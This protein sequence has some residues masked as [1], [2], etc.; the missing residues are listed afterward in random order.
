MYQTLFFCFALV[1]AC[2]VVFGQEPAEQDDTTGQDDTA[3]ILALSKLGAQLQLNDQRIIGVALDGEEIDD[4]SLELLA[5]LDRL[6]SLMLRNTKV[7]GIGLK[8]LEDLTLLGSLTIHN[9]PVSD[10]DIDELAALNSVVIYDLR[11]TKISGMG[12]QR[13]DRILKRAGREASVRLHFGGFLGVAGTYD[14]ENCYLTNVVSNSAADK[15]GIKV[16]DVITN[17]DGQPVD[18]F[19]DLADVVAL[20]PPE[21]PIAIE[22]KR[23]GMLMKFT[24]EL[25][26]MSSP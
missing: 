16:G 8:H 9:S 19:S 24:L 25:L 1:S 6:Q 23:D 11:G 2:A 3:A 18:N 5:G 20:T 12:K 10:R 14:G 7:T 17:F 4:Q 21:Q 13:L 15:A 26:R 22:V